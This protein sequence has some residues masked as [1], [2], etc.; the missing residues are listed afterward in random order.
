MSF[1]PIAACLSLTKR[2]YRVTY[3]GM[4]WWVSGRAQESSP[5]T[6]PPPPQLAI[7][8]TAQQQPPFLGPNMQIF[9]KFNRNQ[10]FPMTQLAINVTVFVIA[11]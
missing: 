5:T 6:R 7:C 10:Q 11:G 3:P 9:L 8:S 2:D 1:S 4:V